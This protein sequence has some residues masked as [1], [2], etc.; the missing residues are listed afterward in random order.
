[1]SV[2]FS[3]L[4]PKYLPYPLPYSNL[5]NLLP[6]SPFSSFHSKGDFKLKQSKT[7]T[8]NP[9][10]VLASNPYSLSSNNSLSHHKKKPKFSKKLQMV[11]LLV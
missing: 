7:S 2:R 10:K 3:K 11:V 9:P 5:L 8:S 6:N 4:I 1:M